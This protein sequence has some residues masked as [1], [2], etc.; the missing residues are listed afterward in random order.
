MG[1]N[2]SCGSRCRSNRRGPD[3]GYAAPNPDHGGEIVEAEGVGRSPRGDDAG[4]GRAGRR[5]P[6]EDPRQI[7]DPYLVVV[8][9]RDANQRLFAQT[10]PVGDG[11]VGVV[12][13][14]R[15]HDRGRTAQTVAP[16]TRHRLLEADLG[17]HFDFGQRHLPRRLLADQIGVVDR[18]QQPADHAGDG[19]RGTTLIWA[20]GWPQMNI[21]ERYCTSSAVT[22]SSARGISS[23]RRVSACA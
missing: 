6:I 19:R 11:E 16:H 1:R 17:D 14:I 9:G 4:D 15:A 20:R 22:A 13:A 23:M 7:L 18:G 12:G 8:G 3:G 21:P 2:R 10:E 5:Q